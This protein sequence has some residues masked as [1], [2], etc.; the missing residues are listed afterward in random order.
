MTHSPQLTELLAKLQDIQLFAMDVDGILTDG[1]I[2][3]DSAGNETKA[4]H[5]HDGVGLSAIK[6]A[7]VQLAIIT[8][9]SSVMVE[10]RA[11]EL[12]ILHII[13]GRDDKSVALSELAHTLSIPLEKCAYMGDDLPDVRAIL[14]AGVG[15]SVPNACTA[16][17]DCADFVTQ[18]QG[19]HGAVREVCEIILQ[20][21]GE[22]AAFL[23]R[24]GVNL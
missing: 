12:G 7:G 18:Q 16:A 15:F 19:G 9:R 17:K 4:F 3:Y 6:Q 24:F 11:K 5:V 21:K 13:Q 20:A 1:K 2:I 8:G 10:R 23:A 14:A 22:Y